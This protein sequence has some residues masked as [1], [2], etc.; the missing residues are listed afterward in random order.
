MNA[1]IDTIEFWEE[2][3]A[4]FAAWE[5]S[6]RNQTPAQKLESLR[7]KLS[8]ENSSMARENGT[9]SSEKV[10]KLNAE[11]AKIE[12]QLGNEFTQTWTKEVTRSRRAEW[13]ARA[14]AGEFNAKPGQPTIVQVKKAEKTQ[15][16][17][18]S[19]LQKAIKVW[20]L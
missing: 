2:R 7:N 16:W 17:N 13:N 6:L 10:S 19:D 5:N 9:Y 14:T 1:N 15:G 18:T 4:E 3:N 20:G 8:I 12:S 11:I